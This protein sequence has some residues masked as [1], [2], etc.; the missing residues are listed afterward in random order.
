MK[1]LVYAP[2]YKYSAGLIF[3]EEGS[4]AEEHYNNNDEW[5]FLGDSETFINDTKKEIVTLKGNLNSPSI[6]EVDY[7]WIE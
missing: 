5:D 7:S 6:I 2:N 3:V 4:I 1:I